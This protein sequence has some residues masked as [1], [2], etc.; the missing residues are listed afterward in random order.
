[1]YV[2]NTC[3]CGA[4]QGLLLRACCEKEQGVAGE[5]GLMKVGQHLSGRH[6]LILAPGDKHRCRNEAEN[7]IW[8]V[9]V[10]SRPPKMPK[11][12]Q[13]IEEQTAHDN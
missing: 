9:G 5:G 4:S 6:E 2:S 3:S 10:G 11:A 7:Q 1:M 13:T 12:L 8:A